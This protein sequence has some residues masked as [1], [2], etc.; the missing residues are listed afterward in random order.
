M[1]GGDP[2]RH[3]SPETRKRLRQIHAKAKQSARRR[4]IGFTLTTD[5]L[6]RQFE[7]QDGF[8]SYT[9][10]LLGL[11][12][13]GRGATLSESR[14]V[15]SLERL[16]SSRPYEADNLVL[17]CLGVNYAKNTASVEEFVQMCL[18]VVRTRAPEYILP[19]KL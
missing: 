5:D 17:V 15:L 13:R 19:W 1:A 8:C 4:G 6:A 16:D 2:W 7:A 14:F 10:R 9:G 12:P 11:K 3:L 18:D